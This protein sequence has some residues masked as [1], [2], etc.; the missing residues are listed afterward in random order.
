MCPANANPGAQNQQRF[1]KISSFS[2]FCF[3][4]SCVSFPHGSHTGTWSLHIKASSSSSSFVYIVH[5]RLS[6]HQQMLRARTAC[7]PALHWAPSLHRSL[8]QAGRRRTAA[9]HRAGFSSA[10]RGGPI[11]RADLISGSGNLERLQ[12]SATRN[13]G[14]VKLTKE[15]ENRV[16]QVIKTEFG[17]LSLWAEARFG[18]W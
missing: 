3:G 12:G 7:L 10:S 8:Q 16:S 2:S 18:S 14:F 4:L 13:H 6:E 17:I 15:A 5:L 11:H 1:K 9:N